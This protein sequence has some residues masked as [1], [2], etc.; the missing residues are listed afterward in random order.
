MRV[1]ADTSAFLIL[2]IRTVPVENSRV[3]FKN[4]NHAR[5]MKT[6]RKKVL[7]CRTY[8]RGEINGIAIGSSIRN[9]TWWNASSIS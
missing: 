6:K 9:G 1:K 3:C 4:H 8:I 2:I 5:S 7:G